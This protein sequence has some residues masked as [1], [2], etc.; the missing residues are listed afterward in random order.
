M[1]PITIKTYPEAGKIIVQLRWY[2]WVMR[3]DAGVKGD[4]TKA[5]AEE[6][7]RELQNLTKGE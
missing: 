5:E 2:D 1:T 4:I 3:R 6:L 7:I